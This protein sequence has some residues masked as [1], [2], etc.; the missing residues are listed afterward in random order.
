[1]KPQDISEKL[2]EKFGAKILEVKDGVLDP[3]IRIDSGA[4][5]DIARFLRDEPVLA[6]GSLMCLSGV[7]W[8]AKGK[9]EVVYHIYSLTH[10]HRIVL[11]VEVPREI[12]RVPS[13]AGIWPT[14]NWHEREAFDLLG[15]V[16]EGHDDLRR[17]LLPEDWEGHP[18]RKDYKV[19][20]NYHGVRV[21]NPPGSVAGLPPEEKS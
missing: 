12:P 13:V 15:I 18:L 14:A 8:P 2:R 7:D 5:A 4:I 10:R 17:I 6:F 11:K 3:W 1:M 21:M 16:F 9:L 20:E 19:Q